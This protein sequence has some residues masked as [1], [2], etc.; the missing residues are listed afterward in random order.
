MRFSIEQPILLTTLQRV[1]SFSI[2]RQNFPILNCVLIETFKEKIKFITT[3]LNITIITYTSAGEIEREGKLA[4][5][6]KKI[7]S[8]AR[9]LPKERVILE[10]YKNN[11]LIKCGKIEFKINGMDPQEFPQIEEVKEKT[12]IEINPQD[13]TEMIKLT[14]FCVGMEDVNY[15]LNGIFFEIYEDQLKLVATD[16]KRLSFIKR[17]LPS[18]QSNLTTKLSF[19]LPIK[20]IQELIKIIKDSEEVF[21]FVE[22][23]NIGFDLKHTLFITKPIEGEFPNYSQYIPQPTETK[24][25]IKRK[26]LLS[27][28]KRAE[29]LS[30]SDYPGVKLELKKEELL[31]S[32]T[33]P[34]LG[35]VK[36]SI[37]ANFKGTS[38]QIGF[39]PSYLIDVLSNLEEEEVS[40]EIYGPEKPAVL[41]LED[42]IY[43][44]LPMKL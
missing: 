37:P 18:L 6:T 19:I 32:K 44:V 30:T 28:L 21:I 27:A 1:A 12:L 11:L 13:L 38:L 33:T 39:N 35:E 24:L 40:F 20:A 23:N 4:I 5:P 43:L 25:T 16:G 36:E 3:D 14:S 34:Q 9:E 17:K 42:Y 29:L 15:V 7:L 22:K 26:D 2:S 41:R 8:I 31:L 10:S